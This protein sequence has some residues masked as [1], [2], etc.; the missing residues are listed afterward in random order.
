[1]NDL[2]VEPAQTRAVVVGI[3]TYAIAGARPLNGPARDACRF[4]RWLRGRG[5]PA[6]NIVLFASP[7]PGA[8]ADEVT[9]LE[10]SEKIVASP[11][12]REALYTHL[13][14]ELPKQSAGLFWLFWG[15]HGVAAGDDERRLIFADATEDDYSSFDLKAMLRGIRDVRY[16][17]LPRQ[18][19]VVDACANELRTLPAAMPF[20][21]QTLEP[22][23]EQFAILAARSGERAKNDNARGTGVFS[24]ALLESLEAAPVAPFPPDLS[25]LTDAL[26]ARFVKLRAQGEVRQTPVTF[27]YQ[28]WAGSRR[29]LGDVTVSTPSGAPRPVGAMAVPFAKKAEL[30]GLLLACDVIADR[31]RRNALLKNLRRDIRFN[32]T[33]ND[34]DMTDV[35]NLIDRCLSYP[36]GLEEL[37]YLVGELDRHSMETQGVAGWVEDNLPSP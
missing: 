27:W 30:A 23:I 24:S 10:A 34:N 12:K 2:V 35:M 22:S 1:M 25:K 19:V 11:A 15:G 29:D 31:G 9:K 21:A 28:N 32:L 5:V 20:P 18:V 6:E 33:R 3:E 36:K 16:A 4:I 13:T 8:N 17:G 26:I 37:V 7:L 14:K